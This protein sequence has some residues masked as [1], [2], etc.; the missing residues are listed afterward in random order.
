MQILA[1]S[2]KIC[3]NFHNNIERWL[4]NGTFA[5]NLDIITRRKSDWL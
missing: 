2:R 1:Q 3:K 5:R 4:E